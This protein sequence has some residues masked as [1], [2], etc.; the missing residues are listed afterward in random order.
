M[1]C[2]EMARE[3]LIRRQSL[4]FFS[5]VDKQEHG[6]SYCILPRL[7]IFQNSLNRR[8]LY[9]NPAKPIPVVPVMPTIGKFVRIGARPSRAALG[10]ETGR[11]ERSRVA[12]SPGTQAE[13]VVARITSGNIDTLTLRRPNG[14]YRKPDGRLSECYTLA[15][16]ASFAVL[17]ARLFFRLLQIVLSM[18]A[19]QLTHF[20]A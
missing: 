9:G 10:E 1:Y 4:C 11:A 14:P 20:Q 19:P 2:F 16:S 3:G 6:C 15:G 18:I 13:V 17:A 5:I 12:C 7:R 8:A